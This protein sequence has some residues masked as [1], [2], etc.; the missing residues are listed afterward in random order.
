[1]LTTYAY[2]Q[3]HRQLRLLDK[4][5]T[6]VVQVAREDFPST[7]ADITIKYSPMASQAA[8]HIF[9]SNV[10][11]K[12]KIEFL[13]C[14]I[15]RSN[16]CIVH[17]TLSLKNGGQ[18]YIRQREESSVLEVLNTEQNPDQIVWPITKYML[19][20]KESLRELEISQ[21][22]MSKRVDELIGRPQG[23]KHQTQ[24]SVKMLRAKE[25]KDIIAAVNEV[26]IP[27]SK[28]RI[29]GLQNGDSLLAT[30]R[31]VVD[32][33][34]NI[35]IGSHRPRDTQVDHISLYRLAMESLNRIA[36]K[37]GAR[38]VATD[39]VLDFIWSVLCYNCFYVSH[40]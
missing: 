24:V 16:M 22:P 34:S 27:K 39:T 21:K 31:A 35:N 10:R 23:R 2:E 9:L 14:V 30:F 4:Q 38:N 7:C 6:I 11:D 12:L 13:D 33:A 37:D 20:A 8:W 18:Y 28:V 29:S 5:V 25:P 15:D 36:V 40:H 17:R 32:A 1:M 3:E 26:M 19:T